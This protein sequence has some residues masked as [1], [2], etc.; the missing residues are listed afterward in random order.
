METIFPTDPG[1][2]GFFLA[3]NRKFPDSAGT[4]GSTA[5]AGTVVIKRS[6]QVHPDHT[7]S[8]TDPVTG[9]LTPADE[10]VEVY[11]EDFPAGLVK[12]GDFKAGTANWTAN[13]G[14]FLHLIE[15]DPDSQKTLPYL[16]VTGEPNRKVTQ[17]VNFPRRLGGRAFTLSFR[18]KSDV[19]TTVTTQLVSG[20]TVICSTLHNLTTVWTPFPSSG[21]W[22]ASLGASSFRVELATASAA[23]RKVF[24]DDVVVSAALFEHDMA[25]Y[26]PEGDIIVVVGSSSAPLRLWVNGVLRLSS[27]GGVEGFGWQ[28]R[29]A[30]PR[31]QDAGSSPAPAGSPLPGDFNNRYFNG[32]RRAARVGSMPHLA[33]GDR[34]ALER[35]DGSFYRFRLGGESLTAQYAYFRGTGADKD[36]RWLWQPLTMR[37]DTLV[38]EPDS[39]RCYLVWRGSW[40]FED[41]P[42]DR[43]RQLKV[44]VV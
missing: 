5:L 30:D 26:K 36:T 12:D 2:A 8:A 25:A 42:V 20:A 14:A 32:Y 27:P 10:A 17:V 39:N 6:Y 41:Q 35:D 23:G 37:I 21:T 29:S 7:A 4:G 33:P 19:P 1:F 43:Y 28:P 38:I 40:R 31:K 9:F 16:Q 22:P 11:Q 13:S 3:G 18:A 24:Y 34:V 44:E 15:N